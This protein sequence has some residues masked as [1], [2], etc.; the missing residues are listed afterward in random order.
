M[1]RTLA[2]F[3]IVFNFLT[4]FVIVTCFCQIY[5]ANVLLDY[6]VFIFQPPQDVTGLKTNLKS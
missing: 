6:K 1:P 4:V 2:K 3:W 5:D